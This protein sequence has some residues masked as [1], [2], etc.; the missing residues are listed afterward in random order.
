MIS[1]KHKFIFFAIPKNCSTTIREVLRSYADVEE[2]LQNTR[3]KPHT[4]MWDHIHANPHE[5]V[6]HFTEQ[7][8]NMNQ[9][10]KFAFVRNTWARVVSMYIYRS[11]RYAELHGADRYTKD[12]PDMARWLV[13]ATPD[14]F[15]SYLKINPYSTGDQMQYLDDCDF[16]GRVENLQSDFDFVC[17]KI[18]ITCQE[19]PH[20]NKSKHKH[21]TEYYD[22]E[23]RDIVATIYMDEITKY[24][25]EFHEE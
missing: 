19:L 14:N 9:Y 6:S 8:W 1:N 3:I 2:S 25:F 20:I 16:V 5:M 10:F 23:T 13:E 11:E 22:D 18:G 15:K 24:R 12:Y 17:S 7:N 21:Y 4:R